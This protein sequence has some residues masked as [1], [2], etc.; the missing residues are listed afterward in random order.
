M[1]K[2]KATRLLRR[3]QLLKLAVFTGVGSALYFVADR[4]R[5]TFA[6]EDT[7]GLWQVLPFD[8]Q[9]L[10]VHAALLRTGKVLFV[11]GSSNDETNIPFEHGSVVLDINAPDG[12]PVF[13]ADLLNSQGK[14][15][16]LF[17]CAHAALADGRILFGGGTKQYDPFYGINE[18]ITFD[19]QT[20]KWTKV[21]SMA[22]G[23]WYP[24]YTTL[25]DGRVLAVSGFDG[26]GK[27]TLVPEIFSTAT[28][29]WSSL[30]KTA[31]TWPLYA[32]LYLLRDGR[33]FYA[34]GYYGSYVA[35]QNTLPPT[36]WNMTTNATT[37]VGGLTSTT[38]RSQ[39]ASVLLP[40]AQ[41]QKVLLIGGGPATGTGSATRD[42]NIVNLAVSSPVYTKVA[43]LNFARLH[44]SAVL[45]PDRTVLVC[46]GSG[47]DEDAAKAALQAEI[48]D[49]V[50]NTWKVAATATVARLYHSIALLLPDGRV[51]TAGSNPERE[52]E[53]L[54]LEVF[55]PPYLFRGPRPVIESVAQSWN[56]GNAVEIKTPQATDI[57]WISL[58]R[59]GTPTHAFD[60]DQRL[61]DVPFTLNTSGGLTATIPSEPNLA[62]PGWYM[63]FITD[64]DKVPSVAA[65]V[66]LKPSTSPTTFSLQ[67]STSPGRSGPTP[68]QGKTVSG[69]LYVFLTPE[70]GVTQVRFFLDNP[71]GSG[72]PT[73]VENTAPYDFK[74][75]SATQANPFDT[76]TISD[77]QHTITAS[78]S[79]SAGGTQTV[80]STFTVAN[81]GPPPSTF[82]LQSS[83]SPGRSGPTPL[84]GK[85]VSGNLYVFLTPESGVTQVRFFLDN[86]SGSGTP[87]QVETVA[88][89]DFKGGTTTAARPFDTK[90]VSNGS[91]TI[92][93]SVTLSSG[94]IQTTSATFTVAN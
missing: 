47:A 77:G 93:A 3:R 4:Q 23:R 25:G 90:T 82:S 78:I 36:L 60:M 29:N 28:G 46:G 63:L 6:Q 38:L 53:E 32:H 69:N 92:T 84:Q 20:Q 18:A 58:I 48:Y 61:V 57:R 45:L 2:F 24:T 71:S 76:K 72:T 52:V 19:P 17:C 74:G 15:I 27:Y 1:P 5:A 83:T 22:I 75:G 43:S 59:P 86:P 56:Y 34:G 67:S 80:S 42:V 73:Q 50:A 51:I 12:N 39:A 79:L 70:S 21:N 33:I 62:P 85:T 8:S 54:R 64:N 31:K 88:P 9:I 81:S 30:A 44:H 16:D 55:S 37:T 7:Q 14:Q 10:A 26:G 87:T 41:D 65:W 66:Q 11:A 49:P 35:N 40:P 94:T 91:H 89:F 68:L 13:P